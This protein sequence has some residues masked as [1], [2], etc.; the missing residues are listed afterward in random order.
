MKWRLLIIAFFFIAWSQVALGK[1]P[2]LKDE[3]YKTAC[4]PIACVVALQALGVNTSLEEMVKLCSWEQDKFLPLENLQ[5]AV[6]SYRGINCHMVQLS[7]K[8]LVELLKDDQT[9]VILAVRKQNDDIDHV[10][11]AIGVQE[12]DQVIHL[13]DYPELHQ[14]KLI[15]ELADSWDGAALVV[16]VSPFYRSLGN[17]ALCF[18]P[19]VVVILGILWFRH[20][21]DKTIVNESQAAS[22]PTSET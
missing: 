12:N 18:G 22:E 7:P 10:V 2:T 14:R 9:V 3:Q 20:R 8:H 6:C 16:R 21:K 11:C 4:G 13:I 17:F 15:A 19:M 1:L 5:K